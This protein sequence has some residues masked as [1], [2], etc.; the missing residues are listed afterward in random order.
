MAED[1]SDLELCGLVTEAKLGDQACLT[2]PHRGVED[3]LRSY[4]YRI[5]LNPDL[6]QDI[7]QET[8][9]QMVTSINNLKRADR[10]W[11]WLLRIALC[12]V[13]NHFRQQQQKRKFQIWALTKERLMNNAPAAAAADNINDRMAKQE[14]SDAIFQAM[15]QLKFDHRN[16]LVLRCFEQISFAEIGEMLECS[17]LSA[18]V[19][20]FRAKLSLKNKLSRRGLGRRN[21]LMAM[22]LFGLLTAPTKAVSTTTVTAA[23][24]EVGPAAACLGFVTTQ[25]GVCTA[26]VLSALTVTLAVK[27]FL[28]FI[29][30]LCFVLITRLRRRIFE[31]LRPRQ[32]PHRRRKTP[33]I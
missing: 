3:N 2:T 27:A 18:R 17:E 30:F 20:F 12:K 24:F 28:L 13:Q 31:R 26:A 32:Q 16:I 19:M 15:D 23:T 4:I 8:L 22:G 10:F 6:T 25:A 21:F 7:L 11:P 33:V 1:I 14:L 5:T 29:A 9:L